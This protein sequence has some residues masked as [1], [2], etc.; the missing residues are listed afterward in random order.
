MYVGSDYW[1]SCFGVWFSLQTS[2]FSIIRIWTPVFFLIIIVTLIAV[3]ST[4][5]TCLLL[6]SFSIHFSRLVHYMMAFKK[7]WFFCWFCL[8]TTVEI[9][10]SLPKF[11]S[12]SMSSLSWI[13]KNVNKDRAPLIGRIYVACHTPQMGTSGD[14]THCTSAAWR[15]PEF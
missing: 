1:Y 11:M 10:C 5:C 14:A 15:Q 3:E 2:V 13:E 12:I 6:N 9:G 4:Q 7:G 8:S